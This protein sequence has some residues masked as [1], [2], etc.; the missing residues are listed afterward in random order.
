MAAVPAGSNV[1]PDGYGGITSVPTFPPH[2]VNMNSDPFFSVY[3]KFLAENPIPIHLN[4]GATPEQR[5]N[6]IDADLPVDALRK[7]KSAVEYSEEFRDVFA[8]PNITPEIMTA[9]D[10]KKKLEE[11]AR[12]QSWFMNQFN[13]ETRQGMED[14]M[15]V[16][17]D[18]VKSIK[19][20][21][22]RTKMVDLKRD[23]I[24]RMGPHS[25]EDYV[26]LYMYDNGD[27][28]GSS[29]GKT[30]D[31]LAP[32][33]ERQS[34]TVMDRFGKITRRLYVP[35]PFD[36]FGVKQIS[37]QADFCRI[38]TRN[39]RALMDVLHRT[40]LLCNFPFNQGD[41]GHARRVNELI[42]TSDLARLGQ[43]NYQQIYVDHVLGIV[44]TTDDTFPDAANLA[45]QDFIF[46]YGLTGSVG[47]QSRDNQ[48]RP[49]YEVKSARFVYN[50]FYL[51]SNPPARDLNVK[52]AAPVPPV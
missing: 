19:N 3:E 22:I 49:R 6:A 10:Q 52:P 24:K 4:A 35:N 14:A 8:K 18:V 37:A 9:L 44:R 26:F 43:E 5:K 28:S 1:A 20:N 7:V 40:P 2:N 45:V 12:F 39:M 51:T 32:G 47:K 48:N 15:K 50:D 42:K 38:T 23:M 27:L 34:V 21:F 30:Y 46:A 16:Y 13:L 31:H 36:I 33:L 41:S 25:F 29:M 11:K 17:P